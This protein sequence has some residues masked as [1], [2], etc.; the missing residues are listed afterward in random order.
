MPWRSDLIEGGLLAELYPEPPKD[1]EDL[2]S[3][4]ID[5]AGVARDTDDRQ[6]GRKIGGKM[7]HDGVGRRELKRLEQIGNDILHS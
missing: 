4:S 7:R 3:P 2:A 5:P 1:V 6:Q